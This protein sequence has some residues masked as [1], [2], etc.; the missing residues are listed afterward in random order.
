M[1]YG[2]FYDFCQFYIY[3]LGLCIRFGSMYLGRL[4]VIGL[5]WCIRG[6]FFGLLLDVHDLF[7]RIWIC[8]ASG[9]SLAKWILVWFFIFGLALHLWFGP[10]YTILFY[11]FCL[12]LRIWFGSTFLVWFYAFGFDLCIWFGS[13]HLVWFCIKF[14]LVWTDILTGFSGDQWSR[15]SRPNGAKEGGRGRG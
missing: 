12:V 10:M 13:M 6:C 7:L 15:D 11:V 8:P 9:F 14:G 5:V 4:N 1:Y 3:G 2:W